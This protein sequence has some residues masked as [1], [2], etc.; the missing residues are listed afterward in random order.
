MK[1]ITPLEKAFHLCG[2]PYAVSRICGVSNT[3]VMRWKK[4]GRLPRTEWTGETHYSELIEAA[5]K[6]AITK[7]ELL[8]YLPP[9]PDSSTPLV[10]VDCPD[11][12]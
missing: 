6:G 2:G 10:V 3:S 1:I 9:K 12:Q 11:S 8:S 4:S 7:A 5:T